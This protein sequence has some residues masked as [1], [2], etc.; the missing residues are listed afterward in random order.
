MNKLALKQLI[1]EELTKEVGE[2]KITRLKE[3]YINGVLNILRDEPALIENTEVKK[4]LITCLKQL[5]VE[6]L[7]NLNVTIQQQ[8]SKKFPSSS[9]KELETSKRADIKKYGSKGL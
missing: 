9:E 6:I 5:D 3:N 1:R 8:S 7:Q 4:I 2:T